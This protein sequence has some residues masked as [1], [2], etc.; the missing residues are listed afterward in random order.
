MYF[1]LIGIKE[2]DTQQYQLDI[3]VGGESLSS[4]KDFL[5]HWG[6]V[7]V[8]LEEYE[9][10]PEEFGKISMIIP[11]DTVNISVITY[12]DT[13]EKSLRYAFALGLVP[14]NVK[15]SDGSV[16]EQEILALIAGISKE[17]EQ[18]R[19][20]WEQTQAEIQKQEVKKYENKD[21]KNALKVINSNIDRIDQMLFI[22]KGIL[23]SDE[24]KKLVDIS[25]ELK[26]I[27]L[28]TNFNKMVRLLS[29]AQNHITKSENVV[30]K[31]LDDKK[32][33]IDRNSSVTNIDVISEYAELVK[34]EEKF[35]LKKPLTATES[36]YLSGKSATVFSVFF[37]K[38]LSQTFSSLS[39]L[40][41]STISLL[42]YLTLSIIAIISGFFVVSPLMNYSG[43]ELIQY[44]PVF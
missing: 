36:L 24:M 37:W 35:V 19:K 32:F 14:S 42:E 11:F 28:G 17:Y 29:D 16:S 41:P 27:R 43:E 15:V 44:L 5:E 30:L 10:A 22:G 20:E 34:A 9:K 18:K 23:G 38:D 13:V 4:V 8:S 31:A 7:V 6:V 26:K 40:L 1:H 2:K 39:Q 3:L 33:L 12:T 21:I 25:N